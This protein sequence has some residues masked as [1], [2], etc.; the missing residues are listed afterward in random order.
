MSGLSLNSVG[1][2]NAAQE[3]AAVRNGDQKAKNAYQVGMAFEKMLLNQLTQEM[4]NTATTSG[5]DS[6]DSS[7]GSGSS[8]GS[9]S[10]LMGSD[11]ASS[12]YGQMLPDALSSG[13]MSSGGLGVAMQIAKALD[14]ALAS[15]TGTTTSAAGAATTSAGGSAATTSAGGTAGTTGTSGSAT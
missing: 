6:S 13:I 8:D 15:A 4:A 11:A 2:V 9:A 14:P 7:D 12:T 10:G 3:P 1:P 5:D